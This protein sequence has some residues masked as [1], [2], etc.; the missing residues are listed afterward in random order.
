MSRGAIKKIDELG[1]IVIPKDIRKSLSIKTN[2][3]LEIGIVGNAI[4]I[5]KNVSIKNYDAISK[6]YA[7]I[8]S[9]CGI[10]LLV[11][12]R[13]NIIYNNTEIEDLKVNELVNLSLYE[14]I[15]RK[16]NY[17]DNCDIRP[18]IIDSNPE[19]IVIIM[20]SK[21]NELVGELFNILVTSDLDITY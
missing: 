16:K 6:R 20:H 15:E 19:G 13:E 1:R 2:D 9:R 7:N 10:K 14:L 4:N 8:F 5:E 12:N 17:C 21:S 11:T 18:I 3:S